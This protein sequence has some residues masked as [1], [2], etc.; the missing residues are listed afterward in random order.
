[1]AVPSDIS[2]LVGW[3]KADA[4]TGLSDGASVASWVD[5]S[6]TA[7]N[8]TQ[9]TSADRPIY[10]TGIV[11][12]L[13]VV[14]FQDTS[15]SLTVASPGTYSA[16][17]IFAVV[18]FPNTTADSPIFRHTS[19]GG[20]EWRCQSPGVLN[21][22]RRGIA[23]VFTGTTTLSTSSFTIVTLSSSNAAN[24][25]AQ[26]INGTVESTASGG[27]DPDSSGAY[28]FGRMNASGNFDYAELIVYNSA[29]SDT[30]R[31]AI[32]SYLGSKYAITVAGGA[33]A[34]TVGA[35]TANATGAAPGSAARVV[36]NAAT[37]NATGAAP[38]PAASS[39]QAVTAATTNATGAAPAG[40]TSVRSGASPAQSTGTA[41]DTVATSSATVAA[42]SANAT[43]AANSPSALTAVVASTTTA[44]A[45][46]A[47]PASPLRIGV[48]PAPASSIGAAAN[49][50]ASSNSNVVV[51]A[52]V[53]TANGTAALVAT[54]AAN[55][56]ATA[57]ATGQAPTATAGSSTSATVAPAGAQAVG[58]AVAAASSVTADIGPA[59]ATGTALFVPGL[60]TSLLLIA[61]DAVEATGQALSAT[62]TNAMLA[63]AQRASA[64]GS[65]GGASVT[66]EGAEPGPTLIGVADV[67][68][69]AGS[70]ADSRVHLAAAPIGA[71]VAGSAAGPGTRVLV[72]PTAAA[73]RGAAGNAQTS[74]VRPLSRPRAGTP[75]LRELV[76][77]GAP[78][79]GSA[80]RVV[81]TA[82]RTRT[83]RTADTPIQ[84][85]ARRRP[86][87]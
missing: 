84:R 6:T 18:R 69:G 13:P 23:N 58:Q 32:T 42:I 15:D 87:A 50:L 11:N 66:E 55:T 60:S 27:N 67:A 25:H 31:N 1:M 8:A 17:T 41:V 63:S 28:E 7:G 14:R 4:I 59:S 68:E 38:A 83:V 86:W 70:A 71:H 52:A 61:D 81:A 33:P 49:A 21:L 44:G 62:T 29:L 73:A 48:A 43:G 12:G 80:T 76:A 79:A 34:T 78:T 54:S 39:T 2:G 19:N 75:Q 16:T 57:A 72:R 10:K 82:A 65:A 5:S 3:F 74:N 30:D 20:I 9:A 24:T 46:G 22:D 37:A 36:V 35:T 56:V 26:Y 64:T 45:T 51:V 47:T 40:A 53:A 77:V 85:P